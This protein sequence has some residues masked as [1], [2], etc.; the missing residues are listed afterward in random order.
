MDPKPLLSDAPEEKHNDVESGR[1]ENLSMTERSGPRERNS[2]CMEFQAKTKLA[3][4][5]V[6]VIL[7]VLAMIYADLHVGIGIAAILVIPILYI[8]FYI[9][10]YRCVEKKHEFNSYTTAEQAINGL[11]LSGKYALVTG[12]NTGIGKYTARV[13]YQQGCNVIIACRNTE[14]AEAAKQDIIDTVKDAASKGASIDVYKLDLSSLQSVREFATTVRDKYSS[15]NYVINN[16]GI[17]AL[18]EYKA[19]TEGYE[20]QFAVCHLGHFYLIQLL[21]PTIIASKGRVICVASGAHADVT[22]DYFSETFL[23]KGLKQKD[24]P[25]RADYH[26]WRNYA[27][28]KAC[29][30]LHARELHRRYGA[31]GITTCSLHP[32]LVTGTELGREGGMGSMGCSDSLTFVKDYGNLSWALDNAKQIPLGAA[33]SL[34][35]VSL[36]DGEICSGF[37]YHN[38]R[39][40]HDY[41]LKGAAKESLQRNRKC[42]D[43]ERESIEGRL[44]TLSEELITQKG[45]ALDL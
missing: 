5:L 27:I 45:F 6:I 21:M 1:N 26:F 9:V 10:Y 23:N 30:V 36:S 8:I 12:G 4:Y 15:L 31:Q 39:P 25:T 16:A 32:G 13:L 24:G 37:Y 22:Y 28:A 35:C 18:P 20:L 2:L 14:K 19:S 11:D 33:T 38:C 41:R 7:F 17:M 3:M 40:G 44:W 34:R 43:Y 42:R 29:N